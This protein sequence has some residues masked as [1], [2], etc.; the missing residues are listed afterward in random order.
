MKIKEIINKLDLWYPQSLADTS[1]FG[2]LGL[3]LGNQENEVTGV[4]FTLDL[5]LDVVE[6]AIQKN[7][8]LIVSHHPF[9][10]NPITKIEYTSQ[11]GVILQKMFS[12]NM[13]L[14]AMHTNLDVGYDGVNDSLAKL[15]DL[16]NYQIPR[17]DI[18]ANKYLRYGNIKKQT[19]KE[20]AEFV[21][22]RFG[23]SGVR[24]AGDL[25]K[26]ITTAGII[27]GSGASYELIDQ[28]LAANC[29]VYITG[30][31]SLHTAQY[32]NSNNLAIIEVNHGI[33]KFVF[34]TLLANLKK[35]FAG[36][37]MHITVV[38]TDPFEFIG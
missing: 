12:K 11:T 20:F 37:E 33:E 21:K 6:E 34:H 29:D 36:V 7:V 17:E 4:L 18:E 30:E 14:F 5:T 28:A 25:T 31:V 10:Y 1:D 13:S 9:I 8:N 32:A 23:L 24:V 26:E 35:E 27:G 16:Q 22:S 19:L 38:N 2:K 15:L 3:Q